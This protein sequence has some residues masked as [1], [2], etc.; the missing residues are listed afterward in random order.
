MNE[1][2]LGIA[3]KIMTFIIVMFIALHS[4]TAA[5]SGGSQSSEIP[6]SVTTVF[7]TAGLD[8]HYELS[9]HMKPSHLKGDFDGDRK[10]DIA[11]L[12]KEKSA[13][14][15]G[16]A[17]FHSS[18]NNVVFIGAGTKLG[19]GGDNFDWMDVW[20]V[21]AKTAA[22]KQVGKPA[23]ALVKGDALHVE[24]SESASALIYWNGKRYIWRQMGD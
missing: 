3:G 14:K 4:L 9:S 10:P 7:K 16:I 24:K 1:Q 20:S 5:Q 15:I 2:S 13:G 21:T 6:E 23:A 18:T 8:R 22:A 11:V 12:V 17:V 19:N